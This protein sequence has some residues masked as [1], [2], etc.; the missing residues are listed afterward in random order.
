MK[1]LLFSLV[2]VFLSVT[3]LTSQSPV[4]IWKEPVTMPTYLVDPPGKNPRFYN[5][6]AY[7]GAQ[8]RVYP[9][10]IYESLSDTRVER[11]YDMVFLENE[12][13]KVELLPEIGGRLFGALDKTNDYDFIYKQHVI[14][15]QL[16]GM[17]GAWISGGIEWN[18]PHHHR[19]TAFMP[20]DYVMEEN[21]D[22]SATVWIG[23]LEIRHR[24]KFML[25]ISV[26]PGKSY[27]EITFRPINRTPLP[28][29][30]LY[31]ANVGV[32]TNQEFQ[33]M[34]P[35]STQFGTYHGKNQF[36][37]WPIADEVYNRVEYYDG[38]DI[39]WWKNHP[40][41][42]SIFCWN[43]EDDF[44]GGYDHSRNAGTMCFSNH[45][46]APGKKFW[47][48]STGPRGQ[49]WD[50]ALTETDGP[51]L[52]LMIGGYS[53]NQ[54][55]YSWLQ[56]YESKYLKQYL[57]PVREIGGV[58]NANKDAAVNLELSGNTAQ[59]GFNTTSE[60][61]GAK[62]ILY[63]SGDIIFEEAI[64]IDP[65]NPYMK[66]IDVPGGTLETDL[67]IVLQ[68]A[69]G[70]ELV[71]Y[72]PVKSEDL[73]M[74]DVAE[75]PRPPA[76]IETIEE[77]YYT[78]LR[79]EQFYN[80]SFKPDPYYQ[81]ALSRDP[82]DYRV[83]TA[84]G[85]MNLRKG[86][87]ASAEEHLQRAV[88]RITSNHTK[89]RDGEGYYYLGLCQKYQGKYEVAYKNLYQATW[90][91]A[92]HSAGYY[93]L[94]QIDSRN[95]EYKKA[96]DHLNRSLS[97]NSKNIC[98]SNLKSAILRKLGKTDQAI[99]IASNTSMNDPLDFWSLFEMHR[100]Y[101]AMDEERKAIE[102]LQA[103]TTRMSNYVQWYI[104][105]SLEYAHAGLWD[106]AISILSLV[107]TRTKQKGFDHPMV[108]YYLG[109]YNHLSGKVSQA[110]ADFRYAMSLSPD[111]VFPFR[112]E[113]IDVLELAMKVNPDDSR[114]PC[115]LGNLLFEMQPERA[116]ANWEL[117]RDLDDSYSMV[118]RNL[119]MAYYRTF[120]DI[121]KS[122]GRY[123][124]AIQLNPSDQ[125]LIFEL[126]QICADGRIDPEKRLKMLQDHHEVIANN[127]VSDALSRE[128]MILVQMKRYDEA[129]KVLNENYFKQWEGISKAYGSYV[130]A[131][132]L[133]GLENIDAGQYEQA[134]YHY[135]EALKF[136]KNMM[137]AEP[138]RGGRLCEVYYRMGTIYELLDEPGKA[139]EAYE[140]AAAR[141][142]HS[143]LSD[144]YFFRARALQELGREEE[145]QEIYDGLISLGI[146][147][148]ESPE[149]DFFAKFGEQQTPDDM[150]ADAYYL[151]GLG[152]LG[153]GLNADATRE[154][155]AAVRLNSNHV[156]AAAILEQLKK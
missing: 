82:G 45:H 16:I 121:Q 70:I 146:R 77:L 25:G 122:I 51:E 17:L 99:Q 48:W 113:S 102:S 18:F 12:Y 79:L 38:I 81:E 86:L 116:I 4:K 19:A 83:N 131:H 42:T 67:K 40:E 61:K 130:D 141:K 41:W 134:L 89:P 154:L 20:V 133:L 22:G 32:H 127:N 21:P 23:E 36:V 10:P 90:S 73:P 128:I 103:I 143:Q 138:Y 147:Q 15:P 5:G 93:Q 92:F 119:G 80:P 132:L 35:P 37:N 28:H 88:D 95:G 6:R 148:L 120:N 104:E 44:V 34:F 97:T 68:S 13:I 110:E 96:L 1:Q 84:V 124:K 125:R 24:M 85:L 43:Y 137:V 11:D 149:L 62:V 145:A 31:F 129:M 136:P 66:N 47:T 156:W 87:Y 108:Y 58:K 100:G 126:D 117:S 76:D 75:P 55:D 71:S 105:I 78:G 52:E 64:D 3:D 53:D 140:N 14:K 109:Y 63:A 115:Y 7:Q 107:D 98:A 26:Y 118:Y 54:P 60:R 142:L 91:Q 94:A 2:V 114:A 57:Y 144:S 151:L 8:G 74:P 101:L 30:F 50:E 9:Y 49:M 135:S 106:D 152:Y 56:P 150:K 112:L 153:K 27:F 65:G 39:S 46:I 69:D 139:K 33:V 155:E 59:I 72:V 111:Y 29:S 123:E